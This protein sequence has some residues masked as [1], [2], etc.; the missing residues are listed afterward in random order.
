MHRFNLLT[1]ILLALLPLSSI[2]QSSRLQQQIVSLLREH[3]AEVG[4]AVITG[5]DTVTVNND[6][7]YPMASV[8]KFYQALAV[9]DWLDGNGLPLDTMIHVG[10][11]EMRP[12][13]W[14]PMR[15]EYPDGEVGLTVRE[16]LQYT[17]HQSDNN[18]SDV[19]FDRAG[20]PVAT[21]RY[22]RS[23][24]ISDFA[25]AATEA[26]M[27]DDHS[28]CA[29]NWTSPLAAAR[30]IDR[31][32]YLKN[33]RHGTF[34]AVW[35]IMT[36]CLTGAERLPLPLRD[37]RSVIAHKTGTGFTTAAGQPTAIN[38]LGLVVLPDGR[39]YAIAVF[40]KESQ[41]NLAATESIIAAVSKVVYK[42]VNGAE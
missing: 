10:L 18:A 29:A 17:L 39:H 8:M 6:T 13:T 32:F 34:D 36:G 37:T 33:E 23:L 14:S 42:Y 15:D 5:G 11:E 19:L 38:D 30:L 21:D 7:H 27:Y 1:T 16:L 40:V 41:E 2:A 12:D 31:F 28:R 24:G 35:Q 26:E 22:V 20:G 25:V 4:V 3:R 9:A